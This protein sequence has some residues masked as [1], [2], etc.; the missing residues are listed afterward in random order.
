MLN[1]MLRIY[2]PSFT[3]ILTATLWF[4]IPFTSEETRGIARSSGAFKDT[5]CFLLPDYSQSCCWGC[6]GQGGGMRKREKEMGAEEG[7]KDKQT[8]PRS[9]KI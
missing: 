6:Q 2:V 4:T 7:R 3:L 8:A 1:P 9:F 5:P